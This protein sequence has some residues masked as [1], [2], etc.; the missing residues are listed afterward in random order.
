MGTWN[1]RRR[2]FAWE[3]E[4]VRECVDCISNIVLQDEMVDRWVWKPHSSQRYTIKSAYNYLT[5]VEEVVTNGR[6]HV[7]W[8]KVFPL[9]QFPIGSSSSCSK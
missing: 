6:N 3:D 4:L 9:L 1:W 2:L 5:A 8:I 7:L